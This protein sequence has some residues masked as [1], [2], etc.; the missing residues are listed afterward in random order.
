LFKKDTETLRRWLFMALIILAAMV[1]VV[2]FYNY[3][4]AILGDLLGFLGL[5][6]FPFI[7]AWIVCIFT[8][9]MIQGLE[10]YLRLP[11]TVA[12]LLTMLLCLGAFSA[13]LTA[14]VL[15]VIGIVAELSTY[16]SHPENSLALIVAQLQ[17]L[18][19]FLD[20]DFT[21]VQE[22]FTYFG[23]AAGSLA[24]QGVN[25]AMYILRI[26]PIAILLVV[27][28]IVATFY[29][30]RDEEAIKRVVGT[31]FKPSRRQAVFEN[32]DA[33][34]RVIGGYLRSQILL[35]LVAIFVCTVGLTILG[36]PNNLTMGLLAGGLDFIPILGPGTILV[37]WGIWLLIN[38]QYIQGF[39]ML[40]IFVVM[41]IV[42]NLLTPKI[43]G[44]QMGLHPLAAVSSIFIGLVLF[45]ILGLIMGPIVLAI[46]MALYRQRKARKNNTPPVSPN[47]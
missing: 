29:W 6:L 19:R 27:V 1:A 7:F 47:I 41:T 10:R 36:V 16:F 11:K 31:P 8:R 30:C 22:L 21:Q 26:T 23:E 9:P 24:G 46:A 15:V 14:V 4:P 32:Y 25:A 17:E 20:M 38:G 5:A 34:S 37:P 42:R 35:M 43:V 3:Y 12:V 39:G 33:I 28:T 18:Y 13:L 44:D 45:G 40:G 2:V